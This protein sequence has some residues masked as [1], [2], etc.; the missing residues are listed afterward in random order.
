MDQHRTPA[1]PSSERVTAPARESSQMSSRP[2]VSVLRA[3]LQD[4]R[5]KMHIESNDLDSIDGEPL[6]SEEMAMLDAYSDEEAYIQAVTTSGVAPA[7]RRQ[8]HQ[9]PRVR[10]DVPRPPCREG[11]SY[12][13]PSGGAS[14]EAAACEQEYDTGHCTVTAI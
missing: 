12:A 1:R 4:A 3:R 9:H 2:P 11:A 14:Q 7:S 8:E 13:L 5:K 6:T 10:D